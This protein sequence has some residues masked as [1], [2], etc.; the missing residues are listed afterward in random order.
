M[1]RQVNHMIIVFTA[2][3][4]LV[5]VMIVTIMKG[6]YSDLRREIYFRHHSKLSFGYFLGYLPSEYY[7]QYI[8]KVIDATENYEL[9]GIA[10]RE[11]HNGL[12]HYALLKSKTGQWDE[13]FLVDSDSMSLHFHDRSNWLT[14]IVNIKFL[15]IYLKDKNI[16][17]RNEIIESFILL[18][19]GFGELQY[20][21]IKDEQSLND[22]FNENEDYGFLNIHHENDFNV[23]FEN[24]NYYEFLNWGVFEI[25]IEIEN[26]QITTIAD[27]NIFLYA[28]L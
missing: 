15:N 12:R 18:I 27:R 9:I 1:G 8:E 16:G 25:R 20:L 11:K 28:T 22:F 3:L 23:N 5:V 13:K 19:S 4:G 7:Q 26:G 10:H 17:K 14:S 24:N 2:L 6:D 21:P